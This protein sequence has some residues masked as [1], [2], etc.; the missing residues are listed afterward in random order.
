MKVSIK[1]LTKHRYHSLIVI[2]IYYE[3]RDIKKVLNE[4]DNL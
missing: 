4:E 2:W 3:V 1:I